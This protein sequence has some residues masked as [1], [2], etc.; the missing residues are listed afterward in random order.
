MLQYYM[1]HSLFHVKKIDYTMHRFILT[2]LIVNIHKIKLHFRDEKIPPI[3][4]SKCKKRD[5]VVQIAFTIHTNIYRGV[6]SVLNWI[7]CT[8]SIV[9]FSNFMLH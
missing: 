5:N 3:S 6:K 9:F 2:L 1:L 8:F 7:I 4:E